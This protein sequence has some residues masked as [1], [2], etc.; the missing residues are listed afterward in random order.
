L[1]KEEGENVMNLITALFLIAFLGLI[2]LRLPIGY[3][4]GVSSLIYLLGSG[5][6]L[7]VIPQIMTATFDSFVLLAVPLFMLAGELMNS[8]GITERLFLFANKLVGHMRGGLAHVNILANMIMAG[9]SGSAVADASGIGPIVI[10]SMVKEGF[11]VEFSAAVTA[12]AS[13]V[14]PIIPP[15]IPFVIYGSMAG[16]SIGGLFLGGAI[17]GVIMG[18]AMMVT[19]YFI[20]LKKGYP[21]QQR[22]TFKE[23][24]RATGK[25]IPPLMTPVIIMGGIFSGIFTPTEA[26][27]IAVVY[28]WVL[29]MFVYKELTFDKLKGVLLH[30]VKNTASLLIVVCLTGVFAWILSY[31][32]ITQAIASGLLC[33][34]HN[35][36]LIL[37]LINI[38]LL[39]V[40]CF[41]DTI[42]VLL[43][44]IPILVPVCTAVGINLLHFGVVVTLNLMVGLLTP[45]VG[46]CLYVISRIANISFERMVK[47]VGPFLLVLL[48]VLL[49]ITYCPAL[50]TLLPGLVNK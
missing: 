24:C 46:M 40:G 41:M 44:V 32:G 16:V 21:R 29:G 35:K 36:F 45:P 15:S 5:I 14:G 48:G 23:F 1:N 49:L 25:A 2:V 30:V 19:C 28:A 47:A 37:L 20:S 26:A 42:P 11:D 17:P 7:M 3:A 22:A 18:I 9:M 8:G 27:V 12:V 50:V 6:S 34:T 38:F 4:L 39:L 33:V 13:T 43:V 31:Q 10:K